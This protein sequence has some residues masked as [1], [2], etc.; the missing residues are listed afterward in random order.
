MRNKVYIERNEIKREILNM[1]LAKVSL[2]NAN[3]LTPDNMYTTIYIQILKIHYN[4]LV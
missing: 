2:C 3:I 4:E 1:V